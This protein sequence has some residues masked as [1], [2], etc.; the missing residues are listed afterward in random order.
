[1]NHDQET[2][3]EQRKDKKMAWKHKE[4]KC[5]EGKRA[6]VGHSFP[7]SANRTCG[8]RICTECRQHEGLVRCFCGWN[9]PPG[10]LED[11]GDPYGEDN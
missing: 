10:G 5:G 8:V 1:M 11:D 2:G 4:E 9:T 3:K 6:L 7:F